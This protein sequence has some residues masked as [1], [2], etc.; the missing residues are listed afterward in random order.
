LRL[1]ADVPVGTFLS[2]GIDSG[3]ITALASEMH[4]ENS[5]LRTFSIGFEDK[6]YNEIAE[7]KVAANQYRTEASYINVSSPTSEQLDKILSSFDEPLGNASSIPTYLIAERAS[8]ELKVV[9]TG[10]GGDELFGGYP[11]YQAEYYRVLYRQL[12]KGLQNVIRSTVGLIPVSHSRI[13]LDYRLK[14]LMRGLS[15]SPERGHFTW[16][17]I[18]TEAELVN[19]FHEEVFDSIQDYDPCSVVEHYFDLGQNLPPKTK[20]M[21]VDL[22]TYL[23][24]DHLRKVDRMTMAHGLEARV[25]FL[26][27]RIVEFAFSL[28]DEYKVQ[29]R[30][31][32]RILRDIAKPYLAAQVVGGSKK[33][34]TSPIASWI[35]ASQREYIFDNLRGGL[36]AQL[37]KQDAVD[38]LLGEHYA[39]S[40]DNSRIIWALLALQIWS[41]KHLALF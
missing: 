25:P 8:E 14:Q 10:D 29:L 19:L 17:E 6:S 11:T 3:L 2:G 39:S 20:L 30:R 34:L 1:Q 31:T 23:L 37:F 33:G 32:K 36:I 26:D 18:A 41:R 24:N 5:R 28:P 38:S 35:T 13:S 7:A 40:K 22:N 27:H 21:Y 9:L 15:F 16:R 12:P 4:N